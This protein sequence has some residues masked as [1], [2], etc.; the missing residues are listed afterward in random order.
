MINL[1][2][3]QSVKI[4]DFSSIWKNSTTNEIQKKILEEEI[5]R[6][7]LKNKKKTIQ[8]FLSIIVF[9]TPFSKIFKKYKIINIIRHL[10]D[11]IYSWKKK[12]C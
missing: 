1:M 8:I 2:E 3:E 12:K 5:S 6:S 10:I 7:F 4:K 11:V 9:F